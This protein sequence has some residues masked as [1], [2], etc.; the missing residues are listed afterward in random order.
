MRK[1]NSEHIGFV[2]QQVLRDMGLEKPLLEHRI[3]EAWPLL[4]GTMIAQYTRKLEFKNGVLFIYLSSAPLRQE[5][6]LAR[7]ELVKKLNEYVGADI[8]QDVRLL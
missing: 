1:T 5:L 7:F 4:M 6:F 2:L 8:V 3:I